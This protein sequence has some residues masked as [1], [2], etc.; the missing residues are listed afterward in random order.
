MPSRKQIR[1]RRATALGLVVLSILLLT[2]YFGE[3]T[4]GALHSVQRGAMEVLSPLQSLASGAIKPARDLVNWIGD[5]A[6]A[7]G[8]NDK[9]KRQLI[10]ERL[11]VARL[12]AAAAENEQLRALIK[13]NDS[14]AFP[15]GAKAVPA[16][17][18]VRSPTEWYGR[19]T[20]NKG[21]SSGVR[22]NQPVIADGALAGRVTSVSPHAAQVT[23][24]T[25]SLGGVAGM[26]SGKKILGVV[27]TSAGG[28][29]G[30][31]DLLLTYIR[32]GGSL[33]V[34]DMVVTSGT[35]D[36][37]G[38]VQSLFPPNIPIGQLTRVDPEERQLYGRVHLKPFV[39]MRD[40]QMVEILTRVRG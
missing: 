13:F 14:E 16:R 30:T 6:Q 1:R 5:S 37:P 35:V 18:I 40:V 34:G 29:A 22:M 24:L 12:Q 20:V 36:R 27:R 9:L 10:D 28:E 11:R 17:V 4:S 39:D 26:V 2:V 8:E 19:V 7:K 33:R 31:D 38:N 25:D 23:L 32:Q 15:G 21:S 3:Q